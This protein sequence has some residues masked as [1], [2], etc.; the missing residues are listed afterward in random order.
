MLSDILDKLLSLDIAH[1]V[2]TSNTVTIRQCQSNPHMF[3]VYAL[4]DRKN[5]TSLGKGR[6]FLH[7]TNALLENGGDLGW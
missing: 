7:T 1:T 6:L 2:D 3:I 5:A 4:P